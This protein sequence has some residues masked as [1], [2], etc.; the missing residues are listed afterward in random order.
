MSYWLANLTT[1]ARDLIT[2]EFQP[3]SKAIS[4]N[5]GTSE[6]LTMFLIEEIVRLR[7]RC[8]KLEAIALANGYCMTCQ[9][10]TQF[11]YE[12]S[13][14]PGIVGA[15]CIKCGQVGYSRKM[16]MEWEPEKDSE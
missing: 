6:A 9:A 14:T 2:K 5:M 4:P 15:R 7:E 11:K 10:F 13:D 16:E 3:Y 1:Q 12:L 8:E